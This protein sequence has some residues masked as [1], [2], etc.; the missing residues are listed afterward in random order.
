M[1]LTSAS[2]VEN[3]ISAFNTRRFK[4][5]SQDYIVNQSDSLKCLVL[6][7]PL[8][9][10]IISI[11]SGLFIG[12]V[13]T[14][15]NRNPAGES[16]FSFGGT[17]TLEGDSLTT[18]GFKGASIIKVSEDKWKYLFGFKNYPNTAQLEN[19]LSSLDSVV[20]ELGTDIETLQINVGS[21]QDLLDNFNQQLSDT[22]SLLDSQV[23]ALN[24][25]ITNVNNY[26][27][28]LSSTVDLLQ[29]SVTDYN[30]QIIGKV[31]GLSLSRDEADLALIS[32]IADSASARNELARRLANNET[33]ID[34]V[35]RVSPETGEVDILAFNYTDELFSEASLRLDGVDASIVAATQRISLSEEDIENLYSELSLVPGQ[36]TA[37]VSS[38][39]AQ[40]ISALNPAHS[41]NFFD[42]AQGWYAVTGTLTEGTFEISTTLGDIR[43]DNLNYNGENDPAIRLR[44]RRDAGTGW[45]GNVVVFPQEGDSI[46]FNNFIE[47]VTI[48]GEFV[49]LILDFEGSSEYLTDISGIR[50]TLGETVADEFTITDIVIGKK[51]ALLQEFNT[52]TARV[53][54]AELDIN[55]LEGTIT[56]KV[57]VTTYENNAVTL[58]NVETVLNGIDAYISLLAT[59]QEL[60]E[61]DVVTK[62]VAAS[63]FIDGQEGTITDIVTSFTS[64]I[65]GLSGQL[66]SAL[67]EISDLSI[68][69]Q[70]IG[71]SKVQTQLYETELDFLNQIAN[72]GLKNYVLN[73]EVNSAA[74]AISDLR[75]DISEDGALAQA[76]VD[77]EAI[78]N[79][80]EGLLIS[81]ANRVTQT[82]NDISG[83]NVSFD[84]LT[85][86]VQNT[87]AGVAANLEQINI[88]STTAEGTAL[89]LSQLELEVS[90]ID[91]TLDGSLSSILAIEQQNANTLQTIAGIQQSIADLSTGSS[92]DISEI[93]STL[94][95]VVEDVGVNA[96]AISTLEGTVNNGTTGVA[97]TYSL[98]S[99]AKSTADGNTS[100]INSITVSITGLESSVSANASLIN[101]V[102]N[103][104]S[105]N[106]NAI[107]ALSAT[108]N[109]PTT[110][111]AALS[112]LIQSVSNDASGNTSAI[113]AIETSISGIEGDIT[114]LSTTINGVSADVSGNTSAIGGIQ[115]ALTAAESDI[116]ANA[117]L[118]TTVQQTVSG[119]T[120]SIASLSSS[121]TQYGTDIASINTELSNISSDNKLTPAEKQR[122]KLE[123]DRINNEYSGI[124]AEG[125]SYG[126][127]TGDYTNKYNG[128]NNYLSGLLS[129]LNTTS[130]IVGT[131]FRDN[132]N[133]Y[134][135]ARQNLL[136]ATSAAAK[137]I[138]DA[139]QSTASSAQAS[140]T[141]AL[142]TL[143][144]I[145]DDSKLTPSEKQV[146]KPEWEGIKLEYVDNVSEASNFNVSST[147]YTEKYN[148]LYNY[149]ESRLSD[150]STTAGID[151]AVFRARY[152]NYYEARQKLLNAIAAKAKT[153]A[154][155]AQSTATGAN[156]TANSALTLSTNLNTE[157]DTLRATAVLAV[158][159]AGRTSFVQL[160]ATPSIARLTMQGDE[161]IFKDGTGANQ[162]YYQSG[163][164]KFSG[165]LEAAGGT[166][167]GALSAATGTFKGSL[168]AATGTFKGALS[169]ATGSFKGTLSAA[170]GTFNGT[171]YAKNFEGDVVDNYVGT[172][173]NNITIGSNPSTLFTLMLKAEQF[174]RTLVVEFT[175][176]NYINETTSFPGYTLAATIDEVS[177]SIQE[178]QP[179]YQYYDG[180]S[181]LAVGAK[182]VTVYITI[183]SSTSNKELEL[184]LE[185]NAALSIKQGSLLTSSIFK[186]GDA[187]NTIT[188]G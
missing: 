32:S 179:I 186:N 129:N 5:V 174:A 77:L 12:T 156:T 128:I 171:V 81:T 187:Y 40:N 143:S 7:T 138:G 50:I 3:H 108:I 133:L 164:W 109:N 90:N 26:F 27:T 80:Q 183:P 17:E 70:V 144:D 139:A 113:S 87:E 23:E 8:E 14:I 177:T 146:L 52:L 185:S 102:S 106:T 9:S 184:T 122:T 18:V 72:Q 145:A 56:Q 159:A 123:L 176:E 154:D 29:E 95:E 78:T 124:L 43:N 15:L 115:T 181:G 151:S 127:A 137:S 153:L 10:S 131:T 110:G 100:A 172:F 2:S 111:L 19:A 125:T 85:L 42:S 120:S 168:S 53:T 155:A 67:Q 86:T 103:T 116:E 51:D 175:I 22:K 140:A 161:I 126:V 167:S 16:N 37:T 48:E 38:V 93:N 28:S 55:A 135:T 69:Q 30:R 6:D 170:T 182:T 47:D 21:Q 97:A 160:D 89:A 147:N 141:S 61:N 149:I 31:A 60:D 163:V 162:L 132:F 20:A 157:L 79:T 166:F 54:Q 94:I 152:A 107:N 169:A 59:Q 112:S 92:A 13:I 105:G 57:D 188:F 121:V 39:V 98:A 148:S 134:Y 71:V 180:I 68:T 104:V 58:S 158:D 24:E 36:I 75:V 88:V 136:N 44:V 73:N 114:A 119:H 65:D 25:D 117:S 91:S 62:A 41:F 11:P 76:I 173:P 84:E 99:Q 63:T 142:S 178:G 45:A 118:L 96:S 46:V 35:V 74:L 66:S 165:N 4:N 64:S 1:A 83:L 82:E 34:A 33:L 130:T 150:L 49:Y 101:T